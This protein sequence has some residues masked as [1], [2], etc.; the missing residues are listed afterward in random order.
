MNDINLII[1][2]LKENE[3]IANK[4][5][6]IE[7]KI[8]SILFFVSVILTSFMSYNSNKIIFYKLLYK[9]ISII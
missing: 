5:F 4:F 7:S 9:P 2:R 3:E 8:L 6:E 1:S